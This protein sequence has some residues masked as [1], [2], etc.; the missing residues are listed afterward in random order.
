MAYV[1]QSALALGHR[2]VRGRRS[3]SVPYPHEYFAK[4]EA[5]LLA[6]GIN[7]EEIFK[8]IKANEALSNNGPYANAVVSKLNQAVEAFPD[9]EVVQMMHHSFTPTGPGGESKG[10]WPACN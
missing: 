4:Y 3:M 6:L 5:G 9:F 7:L 8:T 1:S 10:G 2:H